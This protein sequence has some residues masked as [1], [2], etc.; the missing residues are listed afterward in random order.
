VAGRLISTMA[1]FQR[2]IAPDEERA[3]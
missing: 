3:T 1:R 2:A